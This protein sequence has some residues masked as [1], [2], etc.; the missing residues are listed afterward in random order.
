MALVKERGD[1]IAL[2]EQV[3]RRLVARILLDASEQGTTG[4]AR[5][6]IGPIGVSSTAIKGFLGDESVFFTTCLWYD[7]ISINEG[8]S[9]NSDESIVVASSGILADFSNLR[10]SKP[11]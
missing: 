8:D 4:K 11:L 5:G 2:F 1:F 7:Q 6:F 3:T 10:L 9:I